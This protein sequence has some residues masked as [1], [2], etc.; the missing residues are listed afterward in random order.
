[1]WAF[2]Y[3]GQCG[4]DFNLLLVV[5]Y[6]SAL[7]LFKTIIWF[8]SPKTKRRWL[9]RVAYKSMY[10]NGCVFHASQQSISCWKHYTEDKMSKPLITHVR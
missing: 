9:Y 1:M 8:V 2:Y 10:R 4:A 6:D 3:P 7:D 5:T